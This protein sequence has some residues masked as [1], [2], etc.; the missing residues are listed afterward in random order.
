MKD[1]AKA[2]SSETDAQVLNIDCS[3]ELHIKRLDN[4]RPNPTVTYRIETNLL[5]QIS[6]ILF[7][8]QQRQQS[9]VDDEV[10]RNSWMMVAMV[11]DRLL[12]LIFTLLT[13]VISLVLLL[14]HPT[15]SYKHVDQPLESLDW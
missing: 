9:Q 14:N 10:C 11:I 5:K 1:A 15:Y 3:A 6:N 4:Q 12:L 13:T 8:T 2:F 7:H